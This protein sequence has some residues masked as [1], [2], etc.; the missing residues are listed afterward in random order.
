[1]IKKFVIILLLFQLICVKNSYAVIDPLAYVQSALEL[2][3][4]WENKVQEAEKYKRDLEKRAKQGFEHGM[5]CYANPIKCAPEAY[6]ALGKDATGF[7]KDKIKEVKVM[8]GSGL[9]AGDLI[10]QAS[11]DLMKDVEQSYIY[12]RGQGQDLKNLRAN[13]RNNNAVVTD[14]LATMFAKGITTR[15]SIQEED[16]KLY[17]TEFKNDNLDEVLHAQ[18][19]VGIVTDSRLAR[20]LELRAYMVGA[21]ATAELTRQNREADADK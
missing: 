2:Y 12:K 7:V 9:G 1:M 17:Q 8:S 13:R 10:K 6:K 16:G 3:K 20:I 19:V 21:E 4:E 14:E 5:N 11:E 18:M 15:N